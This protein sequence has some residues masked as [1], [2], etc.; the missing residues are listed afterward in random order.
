MQA[1]RSKSYRGLMSAQS[2]AISLEYLCLLVIGV[3]VGVAF[4]ASAFRD[5]VT[6]DLTNVGTSTLGAQ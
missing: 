5:D 3:G 1:K 2:G 4:V 6:T